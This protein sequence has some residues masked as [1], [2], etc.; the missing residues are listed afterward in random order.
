[1]SLLRRL[2]PSKAPDLDHLD[3]RTLAALADAGADMRA[4]RDTNHY[5][6][7]P[8]EKAARAVGERVSRPFRRVDV[9]PAATGNSW[10]VFVNQ[11]MDTTPETIREA[12]REYEAVTSEF[13]GDYDGWEA[14]V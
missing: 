14:A 1:M 7:L 5:L 3:T 2:R 9:R 12:R 10:L 13:G 4:A 11:T 6:Y 8:N